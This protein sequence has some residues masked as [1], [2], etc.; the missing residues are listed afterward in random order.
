MPVLPTLKSIRHV[1][2]LSDG[3]GGRFHS[4]QEIIK[5]SPALR[6]ESEVAPDDTAVILYSS[7]SSFHPRGVMLSH[8]SL[9]SEAV[10]SANGFQQTDKDIVMLFALPMYHVMGL[11]AVLL[12]S[13][14]KG[15]TIVM[16]SG[17]GLSLGSFIETIEKEKGTIWLG[18]PYIFALTAGMAEKEGVSCDLGSLR[19]CGSAGAPLPISTIHKFKRYCGLSIIDF[20]G[21]TEATCHVTCS[22]V[23]GDGRLGSVGKTLPGWEVKIV[24]GNNT[25]LPSGRSGEIIVNGPIMKG[26]YNNPQ[27]TAKV[28]VAG[29][30]HTGD[31][32]SVDEDGNLYI[33]GRK[34][35]TIIVK[36]QNIHPSDV[37][38][39]L[40]TH[41]EVAEVAVIGVPDEL[42]G[43]VVA[44]VIALKKGEV[45][46]EYEVRRFCLGNL[47][48]YKAPKQVIF[49]DALPKTASGEVDKEGIRRQLSIPSIFQ[50]KEV[51]Y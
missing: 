1:I 17:T 23:S 8:Q 11:V 33:T 30:L 44:A 46:T 21:L 24:D 42:R 29:W 3:Y 28:M 19:L 7:C 6:V 12:T 51:T 18:V 2:E 43:E 10:I 35:E 27:A 39:V 45:T 37:E 14:Y 26:Y 41:P 20:W 13:I 16:V 50:G 4:Y 38:V 32:G 25:E 15:S 36:G 49:L 34:K 31:I 48:S 5:A 9:V 40:S 22:P 47:A